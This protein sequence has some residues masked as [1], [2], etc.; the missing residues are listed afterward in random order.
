MGFIL[1]KYRTIPKY[2]WDTQTGSVYPC[3][4]IPLE[5]IYYSKNSSLYK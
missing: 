5:D 4:M 1:I 3:Q 2:I